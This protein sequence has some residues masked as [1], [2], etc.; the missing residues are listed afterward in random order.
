[1]RE[2]YLRQPELV[3][4]L[5]V[6]NLALKTVLHA[7]GLMT[8]DEFKQARAEAE[9]LFDAKMAE[10]LEAWGREHPDV[11]ELLAAGRGYAVPPAAGS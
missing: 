3:R 6:D 1:M 9:R 2:N 11:T 4:F 10:Q 5:L 8:P 7:R